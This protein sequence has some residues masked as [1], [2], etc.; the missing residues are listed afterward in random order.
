MLLALV[1]ATG[2]GAAPKGK[3]KGKAKPRPVPRVA[4]FTMATATQVPDRGPG[5]TAFVGVLDSPILVGKRFK[6]REI[7]D[8][9]AGV[10]VVGPPDQLEDI[11]L[12][13]RSPDG[14]TIF[15]SGDVNGAPGNA[16]YGL[17]CGG[18]ATTFTDETENF[19]VDGPGPPIFPGAVLSPWTNFVQT[20]GYPLSVMDGGPARGAWTMR[21]VDDSNTENFTLTCWRL[22]L[23]SEP[24]D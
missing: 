19:I 3:G 7:T 13:L 9:D 12:Y 23:R 22:T 6:G 10:S 17:D 11:E 2:A 4:T 5:D 20:N 16:S 24:R 8:V 18:F 14:T 1:V 15:L 21:V